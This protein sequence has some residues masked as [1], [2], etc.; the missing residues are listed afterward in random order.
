MAS[1]QDTRDT[2]L[3]PQF[4]FTQVE[5]RPGESGQVSVT[6]TNRYDQTMYS[7]RLEFSFQVGGEWRHAQPV[8]D[9]ADP[10]RFDPGHVEPPHDLVPGASVTVVAP[11]TTTKG[12]PEGVF[13]VNTVAR[14][15]YTDATNNTRG[16]LFKSL[17]QVTKEGNQVLVDMENY[18][19]TLDAL[20][21]DGIVP[22]TTLL[23][24]SHSAEA[25]FWLA[26][27]A[28]AVLVAIGLATAEVL[29]RRHA[30]EHPKRR[31]RG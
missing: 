30:A 24:D 16:A 11:F 1:G 14:F 15:S 20:Q 12:T 7:L 17:G 22:D 2:G 25:L 5:V 31:K 29:G 9:M 8:A 4:N 21:V 27:V 23:V 10:P 3:I 19:A 26:A 28:G 6:V 13:L 18:T